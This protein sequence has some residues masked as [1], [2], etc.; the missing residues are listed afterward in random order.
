MYMSKQE[1]LHANNHGLCL[2]R[3]EMGEEEAYL[4]KEGKRRRKRGKRG[5]GR[6]Q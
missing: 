6:A 3:K 2:N 1:D 5:E 4:D